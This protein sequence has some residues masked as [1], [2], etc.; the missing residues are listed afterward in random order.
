MAVDL[1][2]GTLTRYYTR[3]WE[4]VVQKMA[5]E[6]GL[7]YQLVTPNQ[8]DK[9][10]ITD[11]AVVEPAMQVWQQ[12]VSDA[13][14]QAGGDRTSWKEGVDA[15][16]FTDRIGWNP[17]LALN[18]WASHVEMGTTP[19]SKVSPDMIADEAYSECLANPDKHQI[20]V[21]LSAQF[22]LP[23]NFIF[24]AKFPSPTGEE[25]NVASLDGLI[26]ALEKLN[27]QSWKTIDWRSWLKND[28]DDRS[29]LE[30]NAQFGFAALANMAAEAKKNQ[31]PMI[32][33]F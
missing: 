12:N 16:Y 7:K 10:A 6:Q 17:L 2:V 22:W 1:Y 28:F 25:T 5:R 15:P 9:D 4:N 20:P 32:L 26:F 18:L 3:Q 8:G 19:P 13:L 24:H 30:S 29:N 31:L 14:T 23:A 21:F 11:P 27:E 33:S